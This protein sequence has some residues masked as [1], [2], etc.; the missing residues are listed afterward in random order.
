M[1]QTF[2]CILT[3][4]YSYLAAKMETDP[5]TDSFLNET[6]VS[7]WQY[8]VAIKVITDSLC[9]IAFAVFTWEICK[10]LR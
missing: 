6:G 5:M 10:E 3:C 9:S 8:N 7:T 2:M 1:I 4:A